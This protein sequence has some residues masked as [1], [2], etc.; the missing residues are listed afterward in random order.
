MG[1]A[2]RRTG[3]V[4]FDEAG[5][6]QQDQGALVFKSD[7]DPN[8]AYIIDMDQFDYYNSNRQVCGGVLN[9]E[10][11]LSCYTLA[12][13]WIAFS[14]GIIILVVLWVQGPGMVDTWVQNKLA[15]VVEIFLNYANGAAKQICWVVNS[16][17][18]E[19]GLTPIPCDELNLFNISSTVSQSEADYI[20][21]PTSQISA[22]PFSSQI[23]HLQSGSSHATHSS[24]SS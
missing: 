22:A 24:P 17:I 13:V 15:V 12:S 11:A 19:L 5:T 2:R 9:T 8:Q 20:L 1:V 23:E 3:A 6:A 21:G 7:E 16:K 10:K 4:N 14:V 18:T